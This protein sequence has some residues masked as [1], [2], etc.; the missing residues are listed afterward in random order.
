[1]SERKSYRTPNPGFKYEP[2]EAAR[3][4]IERVRANP[5][6]WNEGIQRTPVD[7]IARAASDEAE[8][9]FKQ[10]MLQVIN[11][12][13]RQLGLRELTTEEFK[14]ICNAKSG[15]WSSGI[16]AKEDKIIRAVSAA[17][18]VTYDVAEQVRKMPKGLPGSDQNK[19]RMIA[20]FEKRVEA[21]KSRGT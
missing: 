11:A 7:I 15:N 14:R 4:M 3:K 21:K 12:K 17:I 5:G 13:L 16:A 2:E 9:N 6:A 10:A 20:Y 18:A 19:Q 1:M 8:E